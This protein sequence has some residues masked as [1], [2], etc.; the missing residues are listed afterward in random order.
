MDR[1]LT[2]VLGFDRLGCRLEIIAAWVVAALG[3]PSCRMRL[4]P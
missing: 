1:R 4:D 3:R 2:L